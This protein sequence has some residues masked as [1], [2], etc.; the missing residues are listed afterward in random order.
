MFTVGG[1]W[2]VVVHGTDLMYLAWK[3]MIKETCGVGI[4]K[5]RLL[6]LNNDFF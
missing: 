5:A 2:S 3:G 4:Y 1:P 6:R